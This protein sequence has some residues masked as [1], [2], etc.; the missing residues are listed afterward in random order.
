MSVLSPPRPPG[1]RPGPQASIIESRPLRNPDGSPH[2]MTRRAWWLVVLNVLVPGSAQ[3]LAG[4]RRLGRFGL[5]ATLTLWTLIVLGVITALL[6]RSLL[7]TLV[8]NWFALLVL[9]IVLVA[10]AVLWLVLTFDTLRLVTL[11][12]VRPLAR[13]GVTL[14]AVVLLVVTGGGALYAAQLTGVTRDTLGAIF[15]QSGPSVPPTDGYYNILLLGADPDSGR[16]SMRPDSISVVSINAETG[17]VTIT[18][19]PRDTLGVPFSEGPMQELF[20]D[21]YRGPNCGT[22]HCALN[23]IFT[24]VGVLRDG[25]ALYPDAASQ[26]SSPGIEAVKDAAS[27]YLGIEIPYYVLIDMHGFAALIDALG[28]VEITVTERLPEGGGPAYA[29]Q[30][31]DEWATGW[32]EP[33]TQVMDGETAQWYAR[34]RYTTNDWSRMKRQRELQE[35]ILRQ[36]TPTN[37]LTRFQEV[38]AAGAHVVE[39][40]IPQSMLPYFAELALEAKEQPITTIE[41]TPEDGVDPEDPDFAYVRELV[42]TALHPPTPTPDPTG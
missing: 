39:T 35:A 15:G 1:A 9:Q 18:G 28:G 33:G 38:A 16:D 12:R 6:W 10:Y 41:L 19:L 23:E 27:G 21:G 3:V 22:A 2:V 17:A 14:L 36:F 20:P 32:I 13:I 26:G 8:T 7:F 34:S 31:A 40:D 24:E 30:P 5:G 25:T 37:V 42:S 4:N 29:G 11:V